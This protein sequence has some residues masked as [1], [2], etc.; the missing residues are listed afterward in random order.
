[1]NAP[2]NAQ[3][4]AVLL[5]VSTLFCAGGVSAQAPQPV[6]PPPTGSHGFDFEFGRWQVHNRVLHAGK[7]VDFAGTDVTRPLMDGSA[8]VEEHTFFRATGKTYG[9]ALRAYDAKSGTWAIWWLDSRAP[10]LP[11]D[12]R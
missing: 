1:M 9:V 8:D 5:T 12:P 7:W 10:H 11:M 3:L 4:G 2:K 6:A